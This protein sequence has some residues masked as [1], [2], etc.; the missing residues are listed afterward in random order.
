MNSQNSRGKLRAFVMFLGCFFVYCQAHK[1]Q[2]QQCDQKVIADIK[3]NRVRYKVRDVQVKDVV[4]I[5]RIF[6]ANLDT[7]KSNVLKPNDDFTFADLEKGRDLII[8]RLN[9]GQNPD[10]QTVDERIKVTVVFGSIENCSDSGGIGLLDVIYHIFTTNHRLLLS[11]TSEGKRKQVEKPAIQFE[12]T[13][14]TEQPNGL[15]TFSP[16]LAYNSTRRLYGGTALQ[17]DQ[18]IGIFD[19]L[20]INASGSQSGN[21]EEVNLSGQRNPGKKFLNTVHYQLGYT[22]TDFLAGNNRLKKGTLQFQFY[23]LSKPFGAN[24]LIFRY[25]TTIEG[26]N[27][28]SNLENAATS[29]KSVAS[30]GYDSVKTYFGTTFAKRDF[31]LAASYGLQLS[32]HDHSANVEFA[33]HVGDISLTKR[34]IPKPRTL[35]DVCTC[36]ATGNCSIPKGGVHK[37]LTADLRLAGGALQIFGRV[38]VGERFFGGNS[39]QNFTNNSDWDILS[40]PFI[41]S[42]PENQLNSSSAIGAIGGTKFLSGNLTVARPVWGRPLLFKEILQEPDFAPALCAATNSART[43][44]ANYYAVKL[45]LYHDIV[46]DLSDTTNGNSLASEI[47]TLSTILDKLP[48]DLPEKKNPTLE[49]DICDSVDNENG[50]Q[51]TYISLRCF[52]HDS[53][54]VLDFKDA[55]Q[56]SEQLPALLRDSNECAQDTLQ[57]GSVTAI[58]NYSRKLNKHLTDYISNLTDQTRKQQLSELSQEIERAS[59]SI[60][61]QRNILVGR[62]DGV[63]LSEAKRLTDVDMKDVDNVLDAV[64]NEINLVAVAPVGMFDVARIFPD[65]NGTRF[66]VGGGLRLSVANL[67]VT[68]GYVVNLKRKQNEGHGAFTFSFDITNIFH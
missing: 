36:Q 57:C 41:R 64:T 6:H 33:K 2:A 8:G 53:L 54:A 65:N 43:I 23:G 31:S 28:Q 55:S 4:G 16:F 50:P 14:P 17:I 27:Q 34:W 46:A 35:G 9:N 51:D 63:D 21:S 11:H 42:I 25:G 1:T 10:S 18:P 37:V 66:G 48:S 3:N 39:P 15:L 52:L 13:S 58:V 62:L 45:D 12:S 26:G 47:N 61:A 38:P 67:N 60:E 5:L 40:N 49:E 32:A 29:H 22:H 68:F 19:N 56:V 20:M 59:L 30:S 44:L 7:L 24:G